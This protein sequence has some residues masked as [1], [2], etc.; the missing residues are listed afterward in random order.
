MVWDWRRGWHGISIW[1][2]IAVAVERLVVIVAGCGW[3]AL[4]GLG[5]LWLV[6]LVAAGAVSWAWGCG[7]CGGV[8]FLGVLRYELWDRWR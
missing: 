7:L 8:A 4:R 5:A 1:I 3:G 6:G 2:C